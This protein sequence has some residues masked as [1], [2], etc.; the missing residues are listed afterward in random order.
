MF[1]TTLIIYFLYLQL[2]GL[3][4]AITGM[5]FHYYSV[6]SPLTLIMCIGNGLQLLHLQF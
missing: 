5:Q 3:T 1:L 4:K 2:Y 6:H